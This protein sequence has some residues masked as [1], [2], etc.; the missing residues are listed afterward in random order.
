MFQCAPNLSE[1]RDPLLLEQV[2]QAMQGI[3]GVAL[4]DLSMDPDHNRM[5]VSLLGNAPGIQ[6]AVLGLFEIAENALDLRLHHGVHP[7][8]G[9]VDVVPFVPLAGETMERAHQLA[10][11]TARQV[12]E[13][14]TLPVLLYEE[15]ARSPERRA[16]P[17]LRRGG[18]VALQE[19]LHS[20]PPDFGPRELHPRLGATVFGA[21]RPLIAFNVVLATHQ[22]DVAQAIARQLRARDGGL[23]SVRA[24][25]LYLAS[26]DR[27][28]ISINLTDPNQVDLGDAYGR[29]L[30][31]AKAHGVEVES[32]EL[33]GMAPATSFLKIARAQLKAPQL[34][35]GQ[36][37]EW[38][39]LHRASA[40]EGRQT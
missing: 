11:E 37:L 14:F 29:V 22:L 40:L 2:R 24:L 20:D 9:A 19:K 32:S 7:R 12:A 3:P 38:N 10:V 1:G 36:V 8:V 6:Q 15:S 30:E 25:G 39:C 17:D 18:L 31:L 4:G 16:L 34:Q 13:R 23:P 28:Q 5:V 27:V 33:I 26:R 21:R 35:P